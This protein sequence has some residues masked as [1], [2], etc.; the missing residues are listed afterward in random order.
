MFYVRKMQERVAMEPKYLGK[1]LNEIVRKKLLSEVEGKCTTECGYIISIISIDNLYTTEIDQETGCATFLAEY[2]ALTLLP[3]KNEVVNAV[4]H[5]INK[6][7]I[8]CF[9]GPLSIFI[10]MHQISGQ[11]IEAGEG[12]SI[13]QSDGISPIMK[14]SVVRVRLIGL[15]IE[16]TKILGIATMNDDYL[17][18]I[19]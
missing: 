11:L 6:M 17:G 14:D 13:V 7:G 16:P 5:E 18:S 9:I 8:F 1:K 10:S 12:S 4:V 2:S 15:K 3:E 19:Q